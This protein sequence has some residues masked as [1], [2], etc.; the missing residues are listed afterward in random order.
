MPAINGKSIANN[1]SVE[2]T[3]EQTDKIDSRRGKKDAKP[4]QRQA[5]FS[6]PNKKRDGSLNVA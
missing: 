2:N 5:N 1:N 6:I 3:P 4:P